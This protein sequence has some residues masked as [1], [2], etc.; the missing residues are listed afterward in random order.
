MTGCGRACHSVQA[1]SEQAEMCFSV[2]ALVTMEQ[3]P[4]A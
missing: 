1:A 2:T 3:R 4:S